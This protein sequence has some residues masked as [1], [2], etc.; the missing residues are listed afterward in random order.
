MNNYTKFDYFI[1]SILFHFEKML[2]N[3]PYMKIFNSQY[4]FI[5]CDNMLALYRTYIY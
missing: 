4:V 5:K 1:N 3:S 2:K